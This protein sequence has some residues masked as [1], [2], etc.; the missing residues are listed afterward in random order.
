MALAVLVSLPILLNTWVHDDI[1][2]IATNDQLHHAG[3]LWKVFTQSYWP[4]P[5]R[6]DLYRPLSSLLFG[7]EWIAGGS[8]PIVA[9]FGSITLFAGVT[10]ALVA[11]STRVTGRQW[12]ACLVGVWFAVQPVHS[13]AISAG[14]NPFSSTK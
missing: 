6:P 2:V 11:L 3:S 1:T 4:P 13:E 14:V 9:R 10:S 12:A 5:Y 7:L 8:R